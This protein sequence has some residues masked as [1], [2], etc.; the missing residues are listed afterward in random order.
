MSGMCPGR[1][2]RK[3]GTGEERG[4]GDDQVV[5]ISTDSSKLLKGRNLNGDPVVERR[6]F[7][8]LNCLPAAFTIDIDGRDY[9]PWAA[10]RH[11]QGY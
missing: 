3:K 2:G 7:H 9:G 10:L 8:V 6:C 5:K 11:H 1:I 4:I